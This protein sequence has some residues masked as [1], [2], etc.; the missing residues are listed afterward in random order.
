MLTILKQLVSYLI[1]KDVSK[2]P[3]FIIYLSVTQTLRAEWGK[4]T[5][6]KC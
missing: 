5:N 1:L 6:A 2:K 4:K 3:F